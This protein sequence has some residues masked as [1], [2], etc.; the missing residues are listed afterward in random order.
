MISFSYAALAVI[1]V[2]VSPV[3]WADAQTM[4]DEGLKKVEGK[5]ANEDVGIEIDLPKD[6]SGF[7]MLLDLGIM[8][9]LIVAAALG[10][11]DPDAMMSTMPEKPTIMLAVLSMP[12]EEG[13]ESSDNPPQLNQAGMEC[14]PGTFRTVKV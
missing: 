6:W 5:Y 12:V 9:T 8:E 13:M 3:F 11:T 14:T 10:G 7:E 1:F 4:E 2:L